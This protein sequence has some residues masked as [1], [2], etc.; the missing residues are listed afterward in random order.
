MA[1]SIETIKADSRKKIAIIGK[2]PSSLSLAPY[3]DNSW[4][5]WTISD[6][7]L[8]KQ[9]PRYD[10]HFEL[11]D[12]DQLNNRQPYL[13]WLARVEKPL[14]IRQ[15]D[16]RVPNGTLFPREELVEKYG[17]YF[18]NTISWLIALA[19]ECQPE[20]IGVWGVDMATTDEYLKQRPSC[21][22]FLGLAAGKGIKVYIPPQSDLLKCA[23]L[24]GFEEWTSDMFAKW[25]AR[26]AELTTR[27]STME[28][29]RDTALREVAFI[30]GGLKF[31]SDPE[32]I[33]AL[34]A[35]LPKCERK[36]DE[37]ASNALYLR[38]ALEDCRE[39]WGQWANHV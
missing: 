17:H 20:E 27:V 10:V 35:D 4:Q 15:V 12:L 8:C 9:S 36:R 31:C 6:L 28:E 5:I 13:E 16:D 23:G 37:A 7:V 18:T 21:E 29:T 14:F 26:C 1:G 22:Y 19:I 11:H 3:G 2:A 38:G 25:K 30:E 33:K 24:Y 39:Y 32:K 34:E